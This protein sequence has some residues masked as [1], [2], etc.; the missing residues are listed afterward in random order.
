VL[1][2]LFLGDAEPRQELGRVGVG[3][4]AVLFGDRT[5]E[6]AQP[7]ALLVGQ[8]GAREKL[9]FF[10]HRRPE[11]LVAHDDDGQDGHVLVGKL[12]LPQHRRLFGAG[13][14]AVVRLHVA[15]ED[16]EERRFAGAV[17]TGETVAPA[18]GEV[19]GDVF[20]KALRT[21]GFADPNDLDGRHDAG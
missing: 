14:V 1:A 10:L 13:D 18:L 5:F 20:E 11:L 16:L 3:G 6:L 19:H 17:G 9:L 2:L 12:V 4:V 21:V 7:F 8:V 15:G